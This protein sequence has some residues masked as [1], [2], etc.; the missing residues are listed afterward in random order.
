[1]RRT[2]INKFS[3]IARIINRAGKIVVDK[4]G[5][6][7]NV[8]SDVLVAHYSASGEYRRRITATWLVEPLLKVAGDLRMRL[9]LLESRGIHYI[10]CDLG[11]D[12][13]F[14]MGYCRLDISGLTH[15]QAVAMEIIAQAAYMARCNYDATFSIMAKGGHYPI[16]IGPIRDP[17]LVTA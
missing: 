14:G 6:E 1:M 17:L 8:E 12:L 15:D 13:E 10:A 4:R 3:E 16:S 11:R 5:V 7:K 9:Y 2:R